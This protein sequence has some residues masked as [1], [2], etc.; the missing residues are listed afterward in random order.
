[1]TRIQIGMQ[2]KKWTSGKGHLASLAVSSLLSEYKKA[3]MKSV[4]QVH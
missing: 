4:N 2:L 3:I 1:M